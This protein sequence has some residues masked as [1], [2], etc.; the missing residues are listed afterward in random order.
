MPIVRTMNTA[1]T[2]LDRAIHLLGSQQALAN[3]LNIRSPSISEWRARGPLGVPAARCLAIERATH[4]AVTRYELR[5]D[6]FGLAPEN[7]DLS[8]SDLSRKLSGNPDDPRNFSVDDLEHYIACTGDFEP[9][10]YLIEK[11]MEHPQVRR[12]RAMDQLASLLP[13][14]E[15]LVKQA[16]IHTD[17]RPKQSRAR[18]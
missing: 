7:M 18:G 2:A 17:D 12:E 11:F 14:I 5:P 3:L 8:P 16:S 10:Y 4:G 15:K 6:V 9:I 1:A 13:E